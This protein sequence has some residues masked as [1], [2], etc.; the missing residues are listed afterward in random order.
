META[1][2]KNLEPSLVGAEN[3]VIEIPETPPCHL[4]FYPSEKCPWADHTPC[5]PHPDTVFINLSLKTIREFWPLSI[6]CLFSCLA[7]VINTAFSFTTAHCRLALLRVFPAWYPCLFSTSGSISALQ[8]SS[9]VLFF[10]GF[11]GGATG[12]EPACQCRRHKRLEFVSWVRKIPW[13]RKW[14]PTLV[15]LPGESHGQR[16]LAGYSP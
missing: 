1:N 3:C 11:P 8:I 9:S 10:S 14:Q 15:F 5:D 6:S 12:K 16:S 2:P 4:T 7:P 13:R